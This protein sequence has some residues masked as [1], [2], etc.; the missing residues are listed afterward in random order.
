MA[1]PTERL[2]P[3]ALALLLAACSAPAPTAN[4]A[5]QATDV[6]HATPRAADAGSS[7]A[8]DAQSLPE[9]VREYIL[10]Q[11]MCRHFSRQAAAGELDRDAAE[12]LCSGGGDAQ[13]WKALIRK[14]QDDATIGSVLL[15]EKPLDAPSP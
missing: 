10:R 4:P 15:A 2:A 3:L 5:P 11:R 14:Y 1:A 12:A 8:L 6:A 7:T 13:T 9:D